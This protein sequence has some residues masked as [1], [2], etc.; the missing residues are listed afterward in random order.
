M[1]DT[2]PKF[3]RKYTDF[4]VGFADHVKFEDDITTRKR[5]RDAF[6]AG[7]I[8]APRYHYPKLLSL[9]D[10]DPNSV[11]FPDLKKRFY[12]G[13]Y[14]LGSALEGMQTKSTLLELYRDANE[15][16]LKRMMLV[17]AAR[18][19]YTARTSSNL[20]T[21]G[22]DFKQTNLELYGALDATL[23]RTILS[24]VK[25]LLRTFRPVADYGK[26]LKEQIEASSLVLPTRSLEEAQL[27]SDSK[28]LKQ[29]HDVLSHR[30]QSALRTI[31]ETDDSVYYN[32]EESVTFLNAFLQASGL[33][34]HG[35]TG[36]VHP[37]KLRPVTDNAKRIF[38]PT[39]LRRTSRELKRLFIHEA[40]VHARRRENGLIYG[41]DIM[42]TGTPG[43]ADVEEGLGVLLECAIDGSF[44]V[45]SFYRAQDRY[46]ALGLALGAD[47]GG[48]RDARQAY[49]ILWRIIAIR[50][51]HTNLITD[52][53]ITLSKNEAYDHVETAFRGTSFRERGQVFMKPKMYYEGLM[54]NIRYFSEANDVEEALTVALLGK[55]DHTDSAQRL[56]ISDIIESDIESE[57]EE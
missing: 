22:Q 52:E 56:A 6:I 41:V 51:N 49:E 15:Y 39:N 55:Y 38:L 14:V 24:E 48:E 54:K 5:Q 20:Y 44:E 26:A 1:M 42:S 2:I 13:M 34:S 18:R 27:L 57:E 36:A 7:E 29:L 19:I 4:S 12:E 30:Y 28:I 9:Y 50:N 3:L 11:Y 21:A 8:Y 46:L 47:G 53:K 33:T 16:R 35:W 31:P 45:P 25:E 37:T 23:F 40:E 32:A 10:Y 17:E 43:F